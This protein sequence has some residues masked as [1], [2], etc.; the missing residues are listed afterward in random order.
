MGNLPVQVPVT[1]LDNAS[2]G[3]ICAGA[4]R[5]AAL[6]VVLLHGVPSPGLHD[7]CKVAV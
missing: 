3:R 7:D 5:N 6:E 2:P 4:P 1:R